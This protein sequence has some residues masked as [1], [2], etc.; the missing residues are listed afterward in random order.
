MPIDNI[1]D[2]FSIGTPKRESFSRKETVKRLIEE[3]FPVA[4]RNI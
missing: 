3:L 4:L 1:H 2:K